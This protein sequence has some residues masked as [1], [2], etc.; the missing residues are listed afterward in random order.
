MSYAIDVLNKVRANASTEYADRVPAATKD[1]IANIGRVFAEYDNIYN[2]FC[3]ALLHKIGLTIVQ[4]ALFTNKLAKFKSGKVLTGQDVEDIFVH[5]FRAAEGAYD[6]E[7]GAGEGGINPFKRRTYQDVEVYYYRMQRRDKYV[8]TLYKD[9]VIRAFNS[10][11]ALENFIT[12][13]F[14]S[15][16]TG[17]EW[18][19]Y[20]HMKKLLADGIAAGDFFDY[21]V[22]AIGEGASDAENMSACKAFIRTVKKAIADLSYPAT[23]Y[24]PAHVKTATD[25]SRLVLFINKDLPAHIDVDL[26]TSIFGAKYAE[27]GVEVVEV[28]NFGSDNS[29]TYALLVDRDWFKVFDVK[30]EMTQLFNPDGLYTNYWLHIWQILSYSKYVNAVRFGT[31]AVTGA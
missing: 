19:E 31:A 8:I 4:I 2:E 28:D 27:L 13:Q 10:T 25:K 3:T 15:I 23:A 26:Y 7:G 12:A 21:I 5:S 24:N 18:D 20:E 1:N 30:N 17:A 14:N 29:G 11:T 22:P 16:Y 6:K 9:D